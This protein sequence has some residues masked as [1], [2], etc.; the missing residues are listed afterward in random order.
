MGWVRVDDAFYD[1]PAHAGLTLEA[2]GLWLWGLAWSNRNLS[3]GSI[4]T[5]AIERMDP[6]GMASGALISSGRWHQDG[7]VVLIHDYLAYQPS[8]ESVRSKRV[9]ERERWQR[10]ADSTDTPPAP[11][12]DS[13]QT[14]PRRDRGGSAEEHATPRSSQPQPQLIEE[15]TRDFESWW[16]EWP[17]KTDKAAARKAYTARRRQGIEPDR[18]VEARDVYLAGCVGVEARFIKLGATFLNGADGPWSEYLDRPVPSLDVPSANGR[19]V[20]GAGNAWCDHGNVSDPDAPPGTPA[21]RCECLTTKK[22][23]Q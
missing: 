2:W 19:W 6:D 14:P 10:R 11:H 16:T 12:D 17:R 20:C 9:K 18:L 3:D 22:G 23:M 13:A 8:A 4:P 15:P 21:S 7:D 1:H 5:A